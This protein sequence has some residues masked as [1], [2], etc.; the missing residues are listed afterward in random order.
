MLPIDLS[1]FSKQI[2]GEPMSRF[3]VLVV[4]LGNRSA[5]CGE[6]PRSLTNPLLFEGSRLPVLMPSKFPVEDLS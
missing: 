1:D 2:V 4:L 3:L 5:R 6:P